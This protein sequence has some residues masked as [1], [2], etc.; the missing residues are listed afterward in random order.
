MEY[1]LN[2]TLFALG[3]SQENTLLGILR[4]FIDHKFGA[5]M[6]KRG[7]DPMIGTF[8]TKNIPAD[9]KNIAQKQSP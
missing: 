9:Q 2:N 3:E 7:Q 5:R 1:I 8:W 6:V 4:M